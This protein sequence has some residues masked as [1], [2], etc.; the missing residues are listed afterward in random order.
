MTTSLLPKVFFKVFLSNNKVVFVTQAD[1][2]RLIES[3]KTD[4]S[5]EHTSELQ[6]R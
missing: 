2:D 1:R 3:I 6:S 4:R 5:E